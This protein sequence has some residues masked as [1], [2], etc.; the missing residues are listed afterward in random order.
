MNV[1]LSVSPEQMRRKLDEAIAQGANLLNVDPREDL[2]ILSAG[3]ETWDK[4]NQLILE[5]SFETKSFFTSGP[6]TDY[7]DFRG[8]SYPFGLDHVEAVTVEGLRN[9]IEKK[10]QRLGGIKDNLDV[11][12]YVPEPGEATAAS[13]V[14]SSVFVIHGRSDAPRLQVQNLLLRATSHEPVVLM[15]QG[16]RGGTIIEKLEEHLG[17]K[18]GFAVVILT[19]DDEG[20]LRGAAELQPR[21]RQNV[22]LELGYAMGRLGR[23]NV[24][25]L[26]EEGVELPSDINGVAYYPLDVHGAWQRHLLGDLKAAGFEVS[27]EALL[28]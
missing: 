27:A 6:K 4:R 23:R 19:G 26:H 9:D 16:N 12:K 22:I 28:S 21:A 15:D 5:A 14:M 25:L 11:Y 7:V 2:T 17:K 18:A 24:T 20:R 10:V 8:L 1:Q 3:Y 13:G